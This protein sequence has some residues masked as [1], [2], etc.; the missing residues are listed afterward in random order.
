[1]T[2]SA[3]SDTVAPPNVNRRAGRAS[4]TGVSIAAAAPADAAALAAKTNGSSRRASCHAGTA[5]SETRTAV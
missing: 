1:M 5:V 2:S 3:R 4:T